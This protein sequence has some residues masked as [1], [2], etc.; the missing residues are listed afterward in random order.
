MFRV[1]FYLPSDVS[2]VHVRC[3]NLTVELSVPKL[4]HDLLAAID[5][6]GMSGER[7]ENLEFC[8]GQVYTLVAHPNLP[9]QKI[10]HET[11]EHKS[12]IWSVDAPTPEV[13]PHTTHY[14]QRANWLGDV[15]VGPNLEAKYDA[16]FAVAGGQHDY[17]N[18]AA[19][20]NFLTEADPVDAREH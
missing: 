5:P 10:Y 3:A 14:L 15:V 13:G 20:P 4:F 7:L 16:S 2:D 18:I 6:S 12:L 19:S 11:G 9:T 8:S 17:R 1:G